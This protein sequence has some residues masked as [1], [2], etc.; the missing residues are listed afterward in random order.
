MKVFSSQILSINTGRGDYF[1]IYADT[2]TGY[3]DHEESGK[4]N[5]TKGTKQD[6]INWPQRNGDLW[7]A[8]QRIINCHFKNLIELWESTDRQ[9]KVEKQSMIKM[10]SSTKRNHKKEPKQILDLKHT[11]PELKKSVQ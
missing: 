4:H 2:T 9:Q 1:F 5:I 11:M 3:K 10:R 6:S 8:L 7:I